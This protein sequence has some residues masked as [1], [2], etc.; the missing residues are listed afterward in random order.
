VLRITYVGHAT[1]L[2]ELDGARL[3]TDPVLR[4]RVLHLRREEAVVPQTLG[5]LDAVLISHAHWDH[6][7]VA[8]LAQLGRD[9]QVVLPRGAGRIVRR[10][11]FANV[12]EVARGETLAVGA[13]A[14]TATDA[15]HD[16][17]R[18]PL[19]VHAPAL[20]YLVE[21]NARIYFAGDTDLFD[22]MADLAPLDVALLPVAGWG[23]RLPPGHLDPR[24]AAEA[25]RLLRPR[26]AV[27]V[28]WGTYSL[29]TK[30]RG[31]PD[32]ERAPADEFRRHAAELAPGVDVRVL[33][34]GE[35]LELG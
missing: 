12:I 7:D 30:R 4:R 23:P 26:I 15:E 5:S 29:V 16:A 10:R 14:V 17:S 24:R 22:G 2:V 21:G 18:G 35:T 33:A 19:G 25:L 1:V 32:A 31:A 13:V 6:L 9:V 8:S 20:G 3:L 34:L 28:H 27:P 11:H